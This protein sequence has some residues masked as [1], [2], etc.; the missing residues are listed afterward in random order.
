MPSENGIRERLKVPLNYT[1]ADIRQR[2]TVYHRHLQGLSDCL[3][4]NCKIFNV[5]QPKGDVFHQGS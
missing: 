1:E 3:A 2:L 4:A 5:D